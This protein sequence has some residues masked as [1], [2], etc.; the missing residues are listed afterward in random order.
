MLIP[1]TR[2]VDEHSEEK[3][4]Y[5]VTIDLKTRVRLGQD[6]RRWKI[7]KM[8][9]P[10]DAPESVFLTIRPFRCPKSMKES[11]TKTLSIPLGLR[12]E[13]I[14]GQRMEMKYQDSAGKLHTYTM[15]LQKIGED[16]YFVEEMLAA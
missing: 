9:K 4:R 11:N 3:P 16:E 12:L 5:N 7:C 8:L 14:E 15:T 1:E 13:M 10:K 2:G 6:Q